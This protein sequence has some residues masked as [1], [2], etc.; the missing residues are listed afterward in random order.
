MVRA[1]CAPGW[2]GLEGTAPR[3]LMTALQYL[4]MQADQSIQGCPVAM[5]DAGA[6]LLRLHGG[7]LGERVLPR[8]AAQTGD[9][10]SV[11]MV[12]TRKGGGADGGAD[13]AP[14]AVAAGAAGVLARARR[15]LSQ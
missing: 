4:W 12:L 15:V 10:P 13:A 1:A 14:R 9:H 11:A 3:A 8:T 6:R 7:E 2:R 5:M